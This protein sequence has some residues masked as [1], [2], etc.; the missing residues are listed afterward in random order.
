M[1]RARPVGKSLRDTKGR[2]TNGKKSPAGR[3][4]RQTLTAAAFG[5]G[6]FESVREALRGHH[7][8]SDDVA[9]AFAAAWTASRI[10][11]GKAERFPNER[12]VDAKGVSMHIWA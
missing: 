2:R 8:G 3:N 9:D 1:V 5:P 4:E 11:A 12:V 10:A 6:A 7:V